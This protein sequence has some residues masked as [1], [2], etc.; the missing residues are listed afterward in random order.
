MEQTRIMHHSQFHD[1][2]TKNPSLLTKEFITKKCFKTLITLPL[3]HYEGGNKAMM[4]KLQYL[5]WCCIPYLDIYYD[6]RNVT[7]RW[8]TSVSYSI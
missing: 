8:F 2:L 4:E 3:I 7:S 1:V 6:H 5:R